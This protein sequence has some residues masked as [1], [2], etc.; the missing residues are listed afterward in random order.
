M[1]H[2]CSPVT[3]AQILSR[4]AAGL[5]S[6]PAPALKSNTC[7]RKA[8]KGTFTS[9]S[10]TTPNAPNASVIKRCQRPLRVPHASTTSPTPKG[11]AVGLVMSAAPNN[12]PATSAASRRCGQR[13]KTHSAHKPHAATGISARTARLSRMKIG[14]PNS[15]NAANAAVRHPRRRSASKMVASSVSVLH[16]TANARATV[17]SSPNRRNSAPSSQNNKGG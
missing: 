14:V 12:A 8:R 7:S 2:R 3:I 5:A 11:S 9:T 13:I 10:P 17:T 16:A 1:R 6:P 15:K 4:F